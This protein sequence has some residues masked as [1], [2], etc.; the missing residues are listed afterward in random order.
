MQVTQ[1]VLV[2]IRDGHGH[3]YHIMKLEMCIHQALL[4][5]VLIV[6]QSL[7]E[8]HFLPQDAGC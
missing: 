6:Y 2:F 7:Y 8:L 5:E 3:H 4:S 1:G